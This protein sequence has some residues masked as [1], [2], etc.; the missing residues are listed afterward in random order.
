ML[1]GA[2]TK[3]TAMI[4]FGMSGH[5]KLVL[6]DDTGKVLRVRE[7]DN[8]ILDTGLDSYG[9]ALN[10]NVDRCWVGTSDTPVAADQ[11]GLFAPLAYCNH[12]Y[13]Y[14]AE[15]TTR[16]V[17]PDW[18]SSMTK[19]YRFGVG[20]AAGELKE[21][22]LSNAQ[23]HAN[24]V[25]WCRCLILNDQGVPEP[26]VVGSNNSLDVHYTIRFHPPLND[27]SGSFYIGDELYNY[28]SRPASIGD[29]G[30][31]QGDSN[32]HVGAGICFRTLYSGGELG[33]IT[34]SI[35]GYSQY[36]NINTYYSGGNPSA[37]P[38][39]NGTHYRD[40]VQNLNLATGNFTNGI[41]GLLLGWHG[42]GNYYVPGG[43]FLYFTQI[44]LDHP[45]PKAATN[46]LRFTMRVSWDRW[47]PPQP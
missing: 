39:T 45:I 5:F 36:E 29:T 33:P 40:Y 4:S 31:G 26:L 8:L 30:I 42:A 27:S 24:A 34:G 2:G 28:T 25:F 22:G 11:T 15:P 23:A 32:I 37:L 46:S 3:G 13:T 16:P 14:G 38:Y 18:V 35:T 6:R 44:K 10:G 43:Q 41:D 21:I 17:A 1:S 9:Q 12:I 19:R 7:F 20:V 47:V